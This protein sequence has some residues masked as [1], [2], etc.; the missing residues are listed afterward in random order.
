MKP[1]QIYQDLKDLAEKLGVTVSEENFRRTGVNAHS[2]EVGH[3]IRRKSAT[4]SG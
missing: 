2:G 4:D 1:E 3:V